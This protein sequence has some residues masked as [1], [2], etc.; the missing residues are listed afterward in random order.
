M[1]VPLFLTFNENAPAHN[2]YLALV[3]FLNEG[4]Q[5]M[6]SFWGIMPCNTGDINHCFGGT[7]CLHLQSRNVETIVHMIHATVTVNPFQGHP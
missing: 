1:F 5:F 2:Q 3:G 6:L 7:F 4:K